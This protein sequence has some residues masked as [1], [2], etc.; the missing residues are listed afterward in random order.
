MRQ[1]FRKEYAREVEDTQTSLDASPQ[2][3]V[4]IAPARQSAPMPVG[5]GTPPDPVP[6]VGAADEPSEPTALRDKPRGFWSSLF[7]KRK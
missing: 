7:K 3:A 6:G 4:A 5:A 2:P 1:L